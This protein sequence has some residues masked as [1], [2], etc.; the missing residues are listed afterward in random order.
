[1]V[2]GGTETSPRWTRQTGSLL[3]LIV[4]AGL[5]LRLFHLEAKSLWSDEVA[6]VATSLGNLIDPDAWTAQGR[7]FD[8]ATPQ[9]ASAYVE[10]AWTSHGLGNWAQTVAVLKQ[11]IHPPFFFWLMN[12]SIHTLGNTPFGLRLPA[13]LFGSACIPLL[14][15]V[16]RRWAGTAVGLLAAA[17]MALSGYQ[18][19]HS[20]DARPYTLATLLAL[21]ATWLLLRWLDKTRS[22]NRAFHPVEWGGLALCNALGLYTHYLYLFFIGFLALY[23]GWALRTHRGFLGWLFANLGL[24]ALLFLPWLPVLIEQRSFFHHV[25]HYTQGLWQPMQLPEKLWRTLNDFLMPKE[26]LLKVTSVLFL[27]AFGFLAWRRKVVSMQPLLFCGL[28]LAVILGAQIGLDLL[29]DTHTVT[30]RR[31]TLLA[32]PA[33]YL[34]VSY[35]LLKTPWPTVWLKRTLV[36]GLLLWTAWNSIQ[37][38]SGHK[39]QSD[40]FQQAAQHITQHKQPGDVVLVHKSGAMAVGMAYY[41]SPTTPMLG[42]S[43]FQTQPQQTAQSLSALTKTAP[44]LWLVVTHTPQEISEA[45]QQAIV[46]TGYKA[47]TETQVPGISVILYQQPSVLKQP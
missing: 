34:G 44:R 43:A 5:L 11:N 29:Q 20:Q 10:R 18:V 9:A 17:L 23:G 36:S 24:S 27:T 2:I 14:F 15:W 6:T 40:D 46:T 32:A 31:Y 7:S 21:V 41:L 42:L 47:Q 16:G 45:L 4:M 22:T 19:A 13:V 28:W 8:P 12:V 30:I 26:K 37:V 25:G 39:F 3:L 38:L 1:M 33:I 35:L